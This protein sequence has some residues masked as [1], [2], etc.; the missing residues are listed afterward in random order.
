MGRNYVWVKVMTTIVWIFDCVILYTNLDNIKAM[1]FT[2]IFI[3]GQMGQQ[4]Y[5]RRATGEGAIF[6]ERKWT[7]VSCRNCG[8]MMA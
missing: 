7:R 6:W 3:W 1:T 2:P 8:T 4:A 5:K